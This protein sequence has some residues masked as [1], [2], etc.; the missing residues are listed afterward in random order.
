MSTI[1]YQL[2]IVRKVRDHLLAQNRKSVDPEANG[3]GES[4]AYRG[5]NGRKCALGCLIEDRNY[6]PGMEGF[7]IHSNFIQEALIASGIAMDKW[8]VR[9]L[10][11]LQCI[12]DDKKVGD[13]PAYF[14]SV[15]EDVS[16]GMYQELL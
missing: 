6:A 3:F 5:P 2:S 11:R 14:V 12:H 9:L 13:W 7:G 4:C 16:M 8:T 15:E 10:S 1:D